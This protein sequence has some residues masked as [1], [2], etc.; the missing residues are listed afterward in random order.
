M[1]SET[2]VRSARASITRASRCQPGSVRATLPFDA[3]DSADV[4]NWLRYKAAS[5]QNEKRYLGTDS[6]V[7]QSLVWDAK[8]AFRRARRGLP[9]NDSKKLSPMR[10]IE[11]AKWQT[12]KSSGE[13]EWMG[14][15]ESLATVAAIT[16]FSLV[17]ADPRSRER[18]AR[19]AL[20]CLGR[21]F[22]VLHDREGREAAQV[23][24]EALAAQPG[25][26]RLPVSDH[27]RR[28]VLASLANF[29]GT[30]NARRDL[31]AA[32]L[33]WPGTAQWKLFRAMFGRAWERENEG[34]RRPVG[35]NHQKERVA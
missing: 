10:D 31:L 18:T 17:H 13:H 21:V 33:P 11:E 24:L 2:V 34:L 15:V 16:A 35:L 1:L 29:A 28:E 32:G 27:R 20:T 19:S 23:F 8:D 5:S 3:S 6:W 9:R 25:F 4:D 14:T 7:V 26:R 30:G 22:A 12:D